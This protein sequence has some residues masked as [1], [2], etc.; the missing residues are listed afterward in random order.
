[1]VDARRAFMPRSIYQIPGKL[2]D[3]P[4]LGKCLT[5]CEQ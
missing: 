5:F 4:A 2:L 3:S 1:M